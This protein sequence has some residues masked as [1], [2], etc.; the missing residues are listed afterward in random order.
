MSYSNQQHRSSPGQ[1]T[2][3]SPQGRASTAVKV[4]YY[5]DKSQKILNPDLLNEFAEE[6]AKK[7]PDIQDKSRRDKLSKSQ[8]RRFYGA[9]KNLH[10]QIENGRSWDK[11]LPLFKMFRSKVYY[12]E[13]SDNKKIPPEFADFLKYNFELVDNDEDNFRAFVLYFEAVLG[14]AY[15]LNKIGD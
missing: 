2:H 6:Q 3:Q 4:E 7:F 14:F 8:I 10:V 9:I 13:R 15:G 12:A 1:P 11:I 5:K